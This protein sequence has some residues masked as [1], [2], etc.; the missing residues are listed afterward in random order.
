MKKSRKRKL[1]CKQGHL[2]LPENLDRGGKCK[3]CSALWWTNNRD[4]QKDY[5]KKHR[6]PRPRKR[7]PRSVREFCPYGHPWISENLWYGKRCKMC[8]RKQAKE[9]RKQ[10]RMDDPLYFRVR[11]IKVKFG[12]ERDV[13][14]EMLKNQ[15]NQC[16]ICHAKF[17]KTP[18]VDHDHETGKVRCLL[19]GKCNLGLGSFLDKPQLLRLAASYLEFHKDA[20]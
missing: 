6:K 7:V 4:K 8:E 3:I 13:Y 12:L 20:Q 10:R 15:N 17:A 9:V 11:H 5:N 1:V 18:H 16:A 19:C 2:R 14:L